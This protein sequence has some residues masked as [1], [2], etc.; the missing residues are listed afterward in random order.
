VKELKKGSEEEVERPRDRWERG[1]CYSFDC[2]DLKEALNLVPEYGGFT[3]KNKK[4]SGQGYSSPVG[5]G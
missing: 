2:L 5:R 4:F 1:Y 3:L